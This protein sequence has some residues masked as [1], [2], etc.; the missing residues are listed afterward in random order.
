MSVPLYE[1]TGLYGLQGAS[2]SQAQ[3]YAL[4]PPGIEPTTS[5]CIPSQGGNRAASPAERLVDDA[6]HVDASSR[7]RQQR[8]YSQ[9][10]CS[11][12]WSDTESSSSSGL[13]AAN[14][15]GES[16]L[17]ALSDHN[18]VPLE[19]PA[20]SGAGCSRGSAWPHPSSG[21]AGGT[22]GGTT[23]NVHAGVTFA[24]Y[25]RGSG[26]NG[27]GASPGTLPL[28]WHDM[29]AAALSRPR[30]QGMWLDTNG[31]YLIGRSE[32]GAL[33]LW[34]LSKTL[35]WASGET[36]GSWTQLMEHLS[37]PA[38]G[39]YAASWGFDEI[40]GGNAYNALSGS[41]AN[42]EFVFRDA[43]LLLGGQPC[44]SILPEV[45]V[46]SGSHACDFVCLCSTTDAASDSQVDW[47]SCNRVRV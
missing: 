28:G 13:G 17:D 37:E 32:T 11:D 20:T 19:H 44:E 27:G 26:G 47:V 6:E 24:S 8:S 39:A 3:A 41:S 22:G 4:P 29:P 30:T 38:G 10:T 40:N 33:W 43:P 2:R 25:G 46:V 23:F 14:V 42:G 18:N 21:N 31:D 16:D 34:D 45:Q 15:G 7:D 9:S 12:I 36:N 5:H 35:G 1:Q